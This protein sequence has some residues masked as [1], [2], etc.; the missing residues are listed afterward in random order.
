AGEAGPQGRPSRP[1]RGREG[2]DGGQGPQ[3]GGRPRPGG[4][5]GPRGGPGRGQ[6]PA[7]IRIGGM[8]MAVQADATGQPASAG[9]NWYSRSPDEVTAA[10]GVDPATGLTA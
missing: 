6:G 4:T 8:N 3:R 9:Q 7:D 5:G 1:V 10:L 2:Q